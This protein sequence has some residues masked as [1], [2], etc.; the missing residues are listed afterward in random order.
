MRTSTQVCQGPIKVSVPDFPKRI[1][2]T[3]TF[4]PV[5]DAYLV[6]RTFYSSIVEV[7]EVISDA[8]RK[9]FNDVIIYIANPT[10]YDTFVHA[11][12]NE[13]I[14]EECLVKFHAQLPPE[15]EGGDIVYLLRLSPLYD[16]ADVSVTYIYAMEVSSDD[17]VVG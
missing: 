5:E 7:V 14:S 8:L 3:D 10:I 12:K 11:L 1:I 17:I 9:K 13:L 2:I 16:G 15:I 4:T 6:I